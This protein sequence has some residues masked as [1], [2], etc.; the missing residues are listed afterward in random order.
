MCPQS[1]SPKSNTP[2]TLKHFKHQPFVDVIREWKFHTRY[3][4]LDKSQNTDALKILYSYPQDVH[5]RYI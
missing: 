4:M 2:Q 5:S 1:P 3:H